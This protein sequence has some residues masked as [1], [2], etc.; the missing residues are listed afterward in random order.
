L[1]FYRRK[2]AASRISGK[3]QNFN[4]LLRFDSQKI[5]WT[6]VGDAHIQP[7]YAMPGALLVLWM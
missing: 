7:R 3:I 5:C 2:L 1:T 4:M 6:E